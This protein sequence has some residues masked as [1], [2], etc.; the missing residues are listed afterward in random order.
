MKITFVALISIFDESDLVARL[1][2]IFALMFLF[3][4]FIKFPN[5]CSLTFERL[6]PEDIVFWD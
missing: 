3:F 2:E 1:K 6:L 4:H 5:I